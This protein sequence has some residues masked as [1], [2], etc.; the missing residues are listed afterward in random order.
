M[1]LEIQE[2]PDWFSMYEAF[3][4]LRHFSPV[5]VLTAIIDSSHPLLL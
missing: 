2:K 5:Q 3:K 4:K 1:Q